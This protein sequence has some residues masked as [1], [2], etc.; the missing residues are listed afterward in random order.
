MTQQ[1]DSD[2][3]L[4]RL[5]EKYERETLAHLEAKQKIADLETYLNELGQQ[6][7]LVQQEKMRLE[8]ILNH[9]GTRIPDDAKNGIKDMTFSPPPALA[10]LLN[11]SKGLDAKAPPPPPP[12]PLMLNGGPPPPPPPGLPSLVPAPKPAKK[13]VPPSSVPLKCFNWT[14]IPDTKV[15]GTIWSELDDSKLYKVLDLGEVDRLFSAHQK[16]GLNNV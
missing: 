10:N 9:S 2:A 5:K 7:Q 11:G 8:H 13:A 15:T 16:N 4:N 14:K 3:A 12:P 1:E 6:M